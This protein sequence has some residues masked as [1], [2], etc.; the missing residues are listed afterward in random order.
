MHLTMPQF[1][2]A[3]FSKEWVPLQ[4]ASPPN[5]QYANGNQALHGHLDESRPVLHRILVGHG[6]RNVQVTLYRELRAVFD[7]IG[8]WASDRSGEPDRRGP[9]ES[10][11]ALTVE[12]FAHEIDLSV[13][14]VRAERAQAAVAYFEHC[15]QTELPIDQAIQKLVKSWREEERSGPVRQIL[16][17]ALVHLQ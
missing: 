6:G 3:Y 10:L 2:I 7:Q 13:E 12:I 9:Q 15:K 17:R 14:A 8:A 1:C 11:A 4:L 16:D 5:H